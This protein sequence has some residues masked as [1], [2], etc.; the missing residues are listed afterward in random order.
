MRVSVSGTGSRVRLKIWNCP[1]G[2]DTP[3]VAVQ[4]TDEGTLVR[5]KA[6]TLIGLGN[7]RSEVVI[8]HPGRDCTITSATGLAVGKSIVTFTVPAVSDSLGTRKEMR[9]ISPPRTASGEV[10]ATCA[11]A[12]PAVSTRDVVANAV[13]VSA[14]RRHRTERLRIMSNLSRRKWK[15]RARER[16]AKNRGE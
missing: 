14:R 15:T 13:A 7:V 10:T 5:L 12:A 2:I 4:V 6:P 9:P 8:V 11:I 16:R 3:G 1:F